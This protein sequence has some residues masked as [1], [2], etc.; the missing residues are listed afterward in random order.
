MP[1]VLDPL[2]VEV[3]SEFLRLQAE[4]AVS[5]ISIITTTLP[6]DHPGRAEELEA[7]QDYWSSVSAEWNRVRVAWL[8]ANTPDELGFPDIS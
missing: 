8:L 1:V 4:A 5:R 7:L 2:A 6:P 3:V